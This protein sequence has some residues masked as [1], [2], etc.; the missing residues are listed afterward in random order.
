LIFPAGKLSQL[1]FHFCVTTKKEEFMNRT[2]SLIGTILILFVIV[3]AA[4]TLAQKPGDSQLA[5]ANDS[6][7]VRPGDDETIVREQWEYLVVAGGNTTNLSASGNPSMRK[8]PK[9][10]AFRENFVLGQNMDKLG[11][12]GWELV[13]ISGSPVD[14]VYYFKRR[15]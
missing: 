11:A 2:I 12:Q 6:E 15:K 10:Q 7:N 13:S 4:K 5:R 8:E 3:L 1:F 14:P 9:V